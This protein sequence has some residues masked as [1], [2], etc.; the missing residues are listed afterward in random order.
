MFPEFSL[1]TVTYGIA[2]SS[3]WGP[4]LASRLP[5]LMGTPDHNRGDQS[6]VVP[7]SFRG[8]NY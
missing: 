6:S 1:P 8:G 7:T 3:S 4:Y 5:A 2:S